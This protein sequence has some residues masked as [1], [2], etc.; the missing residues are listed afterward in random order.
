MNADI[1][2]STSTL[3]LVRAP[4]RYHYDWVALAANLRALPVM[5]W[6]EL[7]LDTIPGTTDG[8]RRIALIS[9]MT[10]HGLKINTSIEQPFIYIRRRPEPT[11]TA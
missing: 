5:T 8:Y 4:K 9:H 2:Q 3:F 1:S 6:I 11:T 10:Y 7:P